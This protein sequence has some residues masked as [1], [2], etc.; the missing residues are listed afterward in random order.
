MECSRCVCRKRSRDGRFLEAAESRRGE[1]GEG[2]G[3]A[4]LLV[5][6]V[7][8]QLLP[9]CICKQTRQA[10]E[11]GRHVWG[12][13]SG[14]FPG[15]SLWQTTRFLGRFDSQRRSCSLVGVAV[16]FWGSS[17]EGVSP[18]PSGGGGFGNIARERPRGQ[19]TI[20]GLAS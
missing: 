13:H 8:S 3:V 19:P 7:P 4:P 14:V 6:E 10:G 18:Y 15:G 5:P 20:R 16:A 1:G 17:R 9:P 12:R 11:G 2:E